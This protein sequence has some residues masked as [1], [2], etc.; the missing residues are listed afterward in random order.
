MSSLSAVVLI[1][2]A[3]RT[4]ST[5]ESLSDYLVKRLAES[6]IPS[7][8]FLIHR[9]VKS[10]EGLADLLEAVDSAGLLILAFPLYVDCL[11][12]LMIQCLERI[13]ALGPSKRKEPQK[14]LALVN[15]GF[16]EAGNCSTALAICRRFAEETA[17]SWAAGLALGGGEA[18][19]GRPLEEARG[20]NRN[21]KRSLDLVAEMLAKGLPVPDEAA[22]LMSKALV[23]NWLYTWIGSRRW[24]KTARKYGTRGRLHARPYAKA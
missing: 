7:R 12:Y 11:P 21:V 2:S 6:D 24:K 19:G 4:T 15:C 14:V 22:R 1:G 18:I 20:L 16:P 5:S 17:R 9:A 3:K 8:K 23:P 10:A 13:A